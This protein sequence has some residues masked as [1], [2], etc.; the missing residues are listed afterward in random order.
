MKYKAIALDVDGTLVNAKQEITAAT[1]EA[2]IAYQKA[3]GHLIIATGRPEPGAA[4]FGKMLDFQEYG[5]ILLSFNGGRITNMQNG[6]L[7]QSITYGPEIVYRAE[8]V[9]AKFPGT[10]LM[11]YQ[12][13]N[14]ITNGPENPYVRLEEKNSQLNMVVVEHFCDL[15]DF[16]VHKCIIAGE[17]SY[18]AEIEGEIQAMMGDT[19]NVYRSDPYFMEI[20]PPNIEKAAGLDK[21]VEYL[22]ITREEL[23]AFGDGFNDIGMIKY[24]GAG[25]AMGNAQDCVK[26]VADYVTASNEEDG[27]AKAIEMYF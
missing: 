10:S 17:G 19:V 14:L 7:I 3:G 18:L 20:V 5:G 24:A 22:G 12:G 11:T 25:F 15:V 6:D 23:A 4:R 13:K 9:S 1:K 2:L 27:I 21:I 26:E 16:P 8:E